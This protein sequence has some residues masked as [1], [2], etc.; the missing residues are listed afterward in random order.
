MHNNE[1]IL[2]NVYAKHL[3]VISYSQPVYVDS[4]YLKLGFSILYY[5]IQERPAIIKRKPKKKKKKIHERCPECITK[6][7]MQ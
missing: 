3:H 4:Y 6:H 5:K 7:S 1:I 2:N